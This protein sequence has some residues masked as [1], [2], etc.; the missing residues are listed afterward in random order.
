MDTI[1]KGTH[2]RTINVWFNVVQ[3]FQRRRIKCESTYDKRRTDDGY[4]VMAKA[5]LDKSQK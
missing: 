5:H 1:L 4:Q 2:P 3:W